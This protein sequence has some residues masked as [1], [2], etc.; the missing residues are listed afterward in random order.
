[1]KR[2]R[3][4]EVS[5][6]AISASAL[7]R[8]ASGATA[9]RSE[10][11]VRRGAAS[12][13]V[14]VGGGAFG[15]WTSFYLQ[16][17]GVPTLLTDA[18]GPGNPRSSS[19]GDTRGIR[20]AYGD[21]EVY[22]QWAVEALARW[23]A[24]DEQWAA[25]LLIPTGRIS[26]APSLSDSMRAAKA[27]LDRNGVEN[28]MLDHDE[29]AYRYPQINPEGV[30]VCHFEP[31]AVTVRAAR[32][33]RVVA[34]EFQKLGGELRIARVMPGQSNGNRLTS[35]TL[36][37]GTSIAAES[38][39]F[40]CGPW[41]PRLFPELLGDRI[42]TPRRDVFYFGTPA[43]DER[44]SW[45]YM[46]NFS[47][48]SQNVYGFPSVDY[49]GVKGCTHGRKRAL[50]SRH[51]RADRRGIPDQESPRIPGAPFSR[52]EGP[53]GHRESGLPARGYSRRTLRHRPSSPLEKRLVD[54]RGDGT[55]LQARTG[56]G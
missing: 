49:R 4:L 34:D 47:E 23:K 35:L 53:A 50:Q 43:G 51:G 8:D 31:T 22:T 3:F 28:E 26:M 33:C 37:D 1:M 21:R 14:V 54:G 46:P 38:F 44:F 5:G 7:P 15:S 18:Y 16:N 55:R 13:V 10:S 40:A 30:E 29:F 56:S 17:R 20:A 2:R 27:V 12:D 36:T 24:W 9:P 39:V 32:A 19:G 45:P 11:R 6:V 48:G 42:A 52:S 25:N 41:L